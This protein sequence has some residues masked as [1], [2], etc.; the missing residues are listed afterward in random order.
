V[1]TPAETPSASTSGFGA[2]IGIGA[3][4]VVIISKRKRRQI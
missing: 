3:I 2:V 1:V 4:L